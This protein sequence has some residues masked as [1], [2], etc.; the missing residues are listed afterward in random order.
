MK[1][2]FVISQGEHSA[3][4]GAG[5]ALIRMAADRG[6]QVLGVFF[7]GEAA[8]FCSASAAAELLPAQEYVRQVSALGIPLL[9]CARSVDELGLVPA[10]PFVHAGISELLRLLAD[11]D[12]AVEL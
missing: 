8:A 7:F 5:P 6:H 3:A 10:A 1:F 11:C 4:S 12:R 2:L 9:V